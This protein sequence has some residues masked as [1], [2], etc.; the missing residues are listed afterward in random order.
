MILKEIWVRVDEDDE[1]D[2]YTV[3]SSWMPMTVIKLTKSQMA[4]V[5]PA[6]VIVAVERTHVLCFHEETGEVGE[7][8]FRTIYAKKIIDNESKKTYD[9][10]APE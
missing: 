1:D 2:P 3:S 9:F 5:T 7:L 8:D 4:D 10:S 6:N